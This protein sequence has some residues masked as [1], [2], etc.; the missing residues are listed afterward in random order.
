MENTIK[1]TSS[2][3]K[4]FGYLRVSSTSQV[5]G[6]GFTRQRAAN[7][8]YATVET[9]VQI[10]EMVWKRRAS[11]G[12]T[13]GESAGVAGIDG[14]AG[15]SD[16][17]RTVAMRSCDRARQRYDGAGNE[18]Y[19]RFL[20]ARLRSRQCNGTGPLRRRPEPNIGATNLRRYQPVR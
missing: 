2:V 8:K 9:V 11:A 7:K 17:V 13:D 5:E 14:C 19:P 10:T 15:L 3:K 12:K 1:A 20:Q 16:G 18:F 6:D 4:A